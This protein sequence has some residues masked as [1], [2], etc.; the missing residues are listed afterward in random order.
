[1]KKRI[2]L[3]LIVSLLFTTFVSSMVAY[4]DETAPGVEVSDV[5]PSEAAIES[6]A[7]D[8][9]GYDNRYDAAINTLCRFNILNEAEFDRSA[10]VTRG[11]FAIAA[12][13][14]LG[15]NEL[16][17]CDTAYE[18]VK[19]EHAASGAVQTLLQLNI[20]SL[21]AEK[22]FYPDVPIKRTEAVK[23][24]ECILGYDIKAQKLGG[25]PTGYMS[26][27]SQQNLFK[28]IKSNTPDDFLWGE[29]AQMLFNALD[30]DLFTRIAYPDGRFQVAKGQNIMTEYLHFQR[31]TDV[32]KANSVTSV[33]DS[34]PLG[35]GFV[36]I[37]DMRFKAGSTDAENLLGCRVDGYYS[38][39]DDD[40][41]YTLVDVRTLAGYEEVKI[42]PDDI[43]SSS[44]NNT[45]R[46]YNASDKLK[47]ADISKAL[48][49]Y[50]GLRYD[51]E[52]SITWPSE[53]SVKLIDDDGDGR[54]EV[55][56]IEKY[57]IYVVD[58]VSPTSGEIVDQYS[59]PD[60][61][62]NINSTSTRL[63]IER[64]GEP[65]DF[66]RIEK[67]NVLSVAQSADGNYVKIYVSSKRIRDVVEA[68]TEDSIKIY[69][70]YFPI[71]ANYNEFR[72]LSAGEKV[73]VYFTHDE[74]AA[75]YGS[76]SVPGEMYAYLY[77][78]RY[79]TTGVGAGDTAEF[80]V[81]TENGTLAKYSTSANIVLNGERM[82][83]RVKSA[84]GQYLIEK[85]FTTYDAQLAQN[86]FAHQ[87]VKLAINDR[88]EIVS[89]DML[90]DNRVQNGGNGY[91]NEANSIDYSFHA[92][93]SVYNADQRGTA[94][95]Y[96]YAYYNSYGMIQNKYIVQN[97]MGINAPSEESFRLYNSGELSLYEIGRLF[98]TFTPSGAWRDHMK[99]FYFDLIDVDEQGSVTMI[100][101]RPH[102]S[103]SSTEAPATEEEFFIVDSLVDGLN[104][105]GMPAKILKG[106]T[107]GKAV[108]Y[109]M[110]EE[111]I[112]FTKYD[113]IRPYNLS[114][115]DVLRIALNPQGEVCNLQKLF[116]YE[117]DSY[118]YLY[119]LRGNRFNDY[120]GKQDPKTKPVAQGY[121]V[122]NR[123]GNLSDAFKLAE[124]ANMETSQ[125][126]MHARFKEVVDGYYGIVDFGPDGPADSVLC[127]GL[128]SCK[129]YV[130]DVQRDKIR[131]GTVA[132]IEPANSG[133]TAVIRNR[134]SVAYDILLINRP[135]AFP[136][137]SEEP[138]WVGNSY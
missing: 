56:M 100:L 128:G 93:D 106:L 46:W 31:I 15:M 57:D 98:S 124:S 113:Y 25:Y 41:I 2:S 104:D 19:A 120:E 62:I 48:L 77:D 53:G 11:S 79:D 73:I 76:N 47:H 111:A 27:A 96:P 108:S 110:D 117:A 74:K 69:G 90:Y 10:T 60:L 9:G 16:E 23:I 37:G 82:S 3:L 133:Q 36:Q 52:T 43:E 123:F 8:N 1:M 88:S 118:S 45:L 21:S 131:L 81:Y 112:A 134:Y 114:R 13:K 38:T 7:E 119:L 4:A 24:L 68:V 29:C 95:G 105:E 20:L 30:V 66:D 132:D 129:I 101:Q 97:A 87:L 75:A 40:S 135:D 94:D 17:K 28:K 78:G 126:V 121:P 107:K 109:V 137:N 99:L 22:L 64:N 32:I 39:D 14:L 92:D 84:R 86:V 63:V 34:Q 55:V 26:L 122:K 115:G 5:D 33:A 102:Q 18:D 85:C 89:I 6:A 116:T 127:V 130:Y 138:L 71:A 54:Y 50:N 61:K 70:E 72:K 91:Y 59:Q 51:N 49:L 136:D 103:G 12:A 58:K 42:D 125:R 35:S 83:K 67:G 44:D 65:Y 80:M